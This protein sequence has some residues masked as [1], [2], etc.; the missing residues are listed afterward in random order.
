MRRIALIATTLVCIAAPLA[1]HAQDSS[2]ED[3]WRALIEEYAPAA[4]RHAYDRELSKK[5]S[6]FSINLYETGQFLGIIPLSGERSEE[7]AA[8]VIGKELQQTVTAQ[9]VYTGTGRILLEDIDQVLRA[10]A[11]YVC[12]AD[13]LP[14]SISL[15]AG[16]SS[17]PTVLTTLEWDLEPIC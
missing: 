2:I 4:Y 11:Q 16:F 7:A 6:L 9:H 14:K 5:F 3:Q 12:K 1:L 13:H 8:D 15:T 17:G 10:A